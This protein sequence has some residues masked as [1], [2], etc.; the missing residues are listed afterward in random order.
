M[1]KKSIIRALNGAGRQINS[2]VPCVNNGGCCIVASRIAER[3]K[4]LGIPA[5]GIVSSWGNYNLDQLREENKPQCKEDWGI[6]FTHVLVSFD[7]NGKHYLCDSNGCK[8]YDKLPDHDPTCHATICEGCL[9]TDELTELANEPRG[10]NRMFNRGYIP[11]IERIID[12]YLPS[13]S[14]EV[15]A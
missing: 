3:L 12:S 13:P 5:R 4:A 8:E 10:W 9:S 11:T 14:Q 6:S 1:F 7:Y 2:D 15:A